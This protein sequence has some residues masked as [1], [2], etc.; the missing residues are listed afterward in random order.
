MLRV[1]VTGNIGSGKSLVCRIF[2]ML[3]IPVFYA[4][5]AAKNLMESDADLRAAIEAA[6][7]KKSF[8]NGHLNRAWLASKVFGD[9]KQ[10]EILNSLVHP[11][12]HQA[13][14][15]W[16]REQVDHP[17]AVEE[18]ALLVES[19]GYKLLDKLIVVSSPSP[20]R[21][22]RVR[23]RDKMSTAAIKKRMANQMEEAEK[24]KFADF[25]IYNDGR[26][27]LLP[28]VLRIHEILLNKDIS[29]QP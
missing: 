27:M 18:A 9:K 14:E 25:I 12:V 1:G 20:L 3:G 8:E 19:G 23:E 4:D 16:F 11:R 10:L 7:G 15:Q 5:T 28:Q 17:Y 6:F 24:L 21:L 22:Q 13:A 2:E 29:R 26:I